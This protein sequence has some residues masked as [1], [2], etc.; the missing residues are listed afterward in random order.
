MTAHRRKREMGT[1]ALSARLGINRTPSHTVYVG[2]ERLELLRLVG[3]TVSQTASA[4]AKRAIDEHLVKH[5]YG[6]QVARFKEKP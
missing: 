4:V 5:G 1:P 3:E 6:A 2:R